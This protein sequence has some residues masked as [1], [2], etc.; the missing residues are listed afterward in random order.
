MT[1]PDSGEP[2]APQEATVPE[3][4]SAEAQES[5]VNRRRGNLFVAYLGAF[6]ADVIILNVGAA[7]PQRSVAYEWI[8][9]VGIFLGLTLVFGFSVIWMGVTFSARWDIPRSTAWLGRAGAI[10]LPLGFVF[11]L[12]G[13]ILDAFWLR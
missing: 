1:Q 5:A 4:Q 13:R 11:K 3:P 7:L 10:V 6:T 8:N 2:P 9:R 12:W